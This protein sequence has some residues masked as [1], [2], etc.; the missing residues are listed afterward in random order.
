[1][2]V[3]P[4]RNPYS[5][6]DREEGILP[7]FK[8]SILNKLLEIL[9][10][11]KVIQLSTRTLSSLQRNNLKCEQ[12]T[13]SIYCPQLTEPDSTLNTVVVLLTLVITCLVPVIGCM[14]VGAGE[15]SILIED[16]SLLCAFIFEPCAF[17]SSVALATSFSLCL[18]FL[19]S[20]ATFSGS[21]GI[22]QCEN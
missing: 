19:L 15:L 16:G 10:T 13:L 3:F 7:R 2:F 5:S 8:F 12:V 21:I 11:N 17:K 1:M 9:T 4:A 18:I 20:V 22:A 14:P 6:G